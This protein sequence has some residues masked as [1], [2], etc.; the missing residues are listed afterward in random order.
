MSTAGADRLPAPPIRHEI[1]MKK[2]LL[3]PTTLL[4]LAAACG[5]TAL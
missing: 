5:V 2:K 4:A 3:V 1:Q